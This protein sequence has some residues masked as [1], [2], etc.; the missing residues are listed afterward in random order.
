MNS[1]GIV[2]VKALEEKS[3]TSET[4]EDNINTKNVIRAVI[5]GS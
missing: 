3:S 2:P 1:S 4:A 5:N